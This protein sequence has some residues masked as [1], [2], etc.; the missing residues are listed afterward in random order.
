MLEKIESVEVSGS[1]LKV[2]HDNGTEETMVL[3]E[4]NRLIQVMESSSDPLQMLIDFESLTNARLLIRTEGS[5]LLN[6]KKLR[7]SW[8]ILQRSSW[9][10]AESSG[11]PE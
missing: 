7:V 8:K 10:L 9:T 4:E 11:L 5:V 2:N 1:E 6:S 3:K